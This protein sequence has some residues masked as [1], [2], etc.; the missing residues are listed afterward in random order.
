MR[1][2]IGNHGFI[3]K[4]PP[5]GAG[6]WP[7]PPVEG[8]A[9]QAKGVTHSRNSS[10]VALRKDNGLNTLLWTLGGVGLATRAYLA[11]VWYLDNS[12]RLGWV[13]LHLAGTAMHRI[14]EG[15]RPDCSF[16][17]LP[18]CRP[19]GGNLAAVLFQ[20]HPRDKEWDACRW[21][22]DSK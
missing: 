19:S 11:Y 1:P 12:I 7:L 18:R 8:G 14:E 15:S 22:E 10:I 21:L 9:K 13:I 6:L 3:A 5:W 20:E 4:S 2:W 16:A 17:G